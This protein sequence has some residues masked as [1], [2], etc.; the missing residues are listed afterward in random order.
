MPKA[1]LLIQWI[2]HQG[3]RR[4]FFNTS[5]LMVEKIVRV[6]AYFAVGVAVIR[7]LGPESFGLLSYAVSVIGILTI[8]S[9]LGLERILVKQLVQTPE[10]RDTII[11]T[12]ISIRV[13]GVAMAAGLLGVLSMVFP[14]D[15]HAVKVVGIIAL[16]M[17]FQSA[18]VI[19]A[20]NQS[21]VQ[22]KYN[23][24]CSIISLLTV[25]A[26][27]IWGI[28]THRPLVFFAWL[29]TAEAAM[30]GLML[31][32][33]YRCT[34]GPL[35]Q[36]RFNGAT[37]VSLLRESWPLVF[38]GLMGSLYMRIDHVMLRDF[39][40]NRAVGE[41]AA[42]VKLA[43]AW[44]FIPMVISASLSP[45]I[46]QSR[47]VSKTFYHRRLLGLYTLLTFI[48]LSVAVLTILW[49]RPL[50]NILYGS[51]Y[52]ESATILMIYVL[53][54]IFVSFGVAKATW[55]VLESQQIATLAYQVIGTALNIA[56]N[57]LWIPRYGAI[58]AAAATL[59][60]VIS[61]SVVVP[62]FLNSLQ[63]EQTVLFLK[64][65]NPMNLFRDAHLILRQPGT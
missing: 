54:G 2:R 30:I 59:A 39:I 7:Y 58:G 26:L 35:R 17:L 4:Y 25:S 63:R 41:Y 19:D 13:I 12:A 11:G 31:M 27:R 29:V 23:A 20:W 55:V 47:N 28:Y 57:L 21:Q 43:E 18:G 36:W 10:R 51:Q 64:S 61:N 46:T 8:F 9:A 49:A 16:G 53:T 40:G 56:L 32:V 52:T 22:A 1:Q 24:I 37:A 60:T 48:S 5:W 50:V 6:I 33:V 3:F 14:H 38:S 15:G 65:F 62:V 45:A 44:Y 34:S 42:A